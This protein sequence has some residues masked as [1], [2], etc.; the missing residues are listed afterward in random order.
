MLVVFY[1]IQL[2]TRVVQNPDEGRYSNIAHN[3]LTSG[4]YVTPMLASTTFLQKP[5][6]YYWLQASAIKVFGYNSWSIRF[7]PALIS[8]LGCLL[9][10]FTVRV[11]FNR[12]TAWVASA[13]LSTSILYYGA[14]HYA[15]M[16]AEVA[17]FIVSSLLFFLLGV[18]R[19]GHKSA[20]WYFWLAYVFAAI[21]FL[22]KGLIGIVFPAAI[23]GVW[24]LLQ[25]KWWL[26]LRIRLIS[27]LV[28]FAIIIAPWLILVQQQNPGFLYTF[29]IQQQFLRFA[30][31]GFNNV[32]PFWF[33]IAI[34]AIGF[35]AWICF[36]PQTI[37]LTIQKIKTKA[38]EASYLL[39]LWIWIIFVFIFFSI[40][41]SK[42]VGYILP[43]FPPLAIV[44]AYTIAE[45]WQSTKL[46]IT[47]KISAI[48]GFLFILLVY[49]AAV[50]LLTQAIWQGN[51]SYHWIMLAIAVASVIVLCYS[52]IG[53]TNKSFYFFYTLF[54][55]MLFLLLV[56]NLTTHVYMSSSNAQFAP[57]L[58]EHPTPVKLVAYYRY[59]PDLNIYSQRDP[60]YVDDWQKNV[61]STGD[62]DFSRFARKCGN[63]LASCS[64]LIT[65]TTLKQ[66]WQSAQRVMVVCPLDRL[67]QFKTQIGDYTV[68]SK[69]LDN[70]LLINDR[71]KAY[72]R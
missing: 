61:N 63:R 52:F 67:S 30:A 20:K 2:G 55:M 37:A 26:L 6:M 43:M 31:S 68:L 18:H 13:I 45:C 16:D 5:P 12:R 39:F 34:I 70:A 72:S 7:W 15:D 69:T 58:A 4:N 60:Y 42:M 3:M 49:I 10:Y 44:L 19:L 35:G 23:I 64:Q 57:Y 41:K 66:W 21:S 40:P 51:N 53:H 62:D 25:N 29:F 32:Q 46:A 1:G 71:P 24:I 14:G 28:L 38:T 54:S 65:S 11:L 50:V 48:Y 33:Y 17:I 27:G 56:N 47:T 9:V 8:V 59:T 36:L 22:T